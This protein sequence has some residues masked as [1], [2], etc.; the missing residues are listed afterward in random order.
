M[1]WA[2]VFWLVLLVVFLAA[3]AATVTLTCLWF[4]AGSLAA[5]VV[6]MTGGGIGFQTAVFLVVSA[7]LLTALRPLVRKYVTPKVTRTNVDSVIAATGLVTAA[8]SN[9]EAKG[10]V[11]LGAMEWSARSS[12][13]EPIEVGTLIRVDR[14]EGVKVFVTVAEVPEKV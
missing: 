13:G 7:A 1:N 14:V 11:R 8:I 5:M 12:S 4:A 3:E 9:V 2:A 10:Q 6:S